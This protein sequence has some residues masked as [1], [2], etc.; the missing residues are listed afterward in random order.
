MRIAM[1][2]T[3]FTDA[4]LRLAAQIGVT[5]I[6]ARYPGSD[7][8][9]VCRVKDQVEK[10]GLRL[11]VIEGYLPMEKA[12]LGQTGRDDDIA[13][14]QDLVRNMGKAGVPVLCYNFMAYR[15]WT[16]TVF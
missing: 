7:V 5:D 4:N 15:E 16:R 12:R 3:P 9:S 1:V 10:H 13:Q 14:I 6:V 11:T 2:V 8:A